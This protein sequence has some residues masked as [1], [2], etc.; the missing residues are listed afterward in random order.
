MEYVPPINGNLADPDR[1][2]VNANPGAS[3]KGSIPP[4]ESIEHPMREILNVIEEA[5]LT[6]DG[7]DLTQLYDAIQALIAAGISPDVDSF[8]EMIHVQD[9][10]SSGTN[11][12]TGTV[13]TWHE[14]V[15]NT[16]IRNTIT[17]ASLSSNQITLP[18]G[19]YYYQGSAPAFRSGT[20]NSTLHKARLKNVTDT[21]YQYGTSEATTFGT[22]RA[23]VSGIFT[24]AGS[25]VVS[26]EHYIG[27]FIEASSL[28]LGQATSIS[29][30]IEI[31]SDL[32]IWK[33][34]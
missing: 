15:L 20:S 3:V 18:A 27:S 10:K 30:I 29:G 25:K 16:V 5:G 6:P 8:N 19:T 17:G 9:Q 4:A 1:P 11:G 33:V 7:G 14:R 34:A 23:E 24:I 26:L 28:P 13:N 32:K 31:Y 21:T 22:T 2:Y 12:G